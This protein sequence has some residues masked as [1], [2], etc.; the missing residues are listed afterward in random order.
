MQNL[1][2]SA[3][4]CSSLLNSSQFFFLKIIFGALHLQLIYNFLLRKN[5]LLFYLKNFLKIYCFSD[6]VFLGILKVLTV[7][8]F[9]VSNSI[10]C[11]FYHLFIYLSISIR[12]SG[13]GLKSRRFGSCLIIDVSRRIVT[14]IVGPSGIIFQNMFGC[15]KKPNDITIETMNFGVRLPRFKSQFHYFSIV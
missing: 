10:H 5:F 6:F 7:N 14:H 2:W 9:Y 1:S 11:K 15:N 4:F 13:A 8:L 3:C 12:Q